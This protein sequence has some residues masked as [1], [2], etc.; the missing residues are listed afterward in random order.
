[1][2]R[3]RGGLEIAPRLGGAENLNRCIEDAAGVIAKCCMVGRGCSRAQ[4]ARAQNDAAGEDTQ[5]QRVGARLSVVRLWGMP[6]QCAEY[7]SAK[8]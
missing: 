3:R 8:R 2:A 1:M 7:G 6:P 4:G 5:Q